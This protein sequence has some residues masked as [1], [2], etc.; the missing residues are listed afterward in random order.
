MQ[1]VEWIQELKEIQETLR[2]LEKA[3]E[4]HGKQKKTT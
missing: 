1:K 2:K 3:F 4:K